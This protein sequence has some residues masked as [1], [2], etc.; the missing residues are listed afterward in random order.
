MSGRLHVLATLNPGNEP[1]VSLSG[2]LGVPQSCCGQFGREKKSLSFA[3]IPTVIH[4]FPAFT[5][6]TDDYNIVAYRVDTSEK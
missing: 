1:L 3:G 5:P 4:V 6:V 2:R